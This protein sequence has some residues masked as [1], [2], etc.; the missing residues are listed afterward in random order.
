[1]DRHLTIDVVN[2]LELECRRLSSFEIDLTQREEHL[3]AGMTSACRG[4]IRKAQKTGVTVEEIHDIRFADEYYAQLQEVFGR[5]SLVPPYSVVRVR[6][7]IRSLGDSSHLLLLRAVDPTGRCIATGIFPAMNG[8]MYFWGGASWRA[9]LGYRP[10]EAI[11][12]YAMRYWK[13][14]GIQRYDMGGGGEY[15]R[16][17]GGREISVPWIRASKYRSVASCRELAKWAMLFSRRIR[18]R[19]WN[20]RGGVFMSGVGV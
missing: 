15:K 18:G 4:C 11:H 19:G 9:S 7:L 20:V 8:T 12:W 16:K 3:W 14:R 17:F 6:E 1:M 13:A 2:K 5:Q 10:N